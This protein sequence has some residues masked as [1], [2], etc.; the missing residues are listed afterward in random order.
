LSDIIIERPEL[1]S[2]GVYEF[3]WSDSDAAGTNARRG[4]N[5]EVIADIS[6]KKSES[7]W[8]LERRMRGYE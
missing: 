7:E 6:A 1:D 3:G 4:I 8:M 2:L 5:E